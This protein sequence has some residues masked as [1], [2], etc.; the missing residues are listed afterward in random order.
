MINIKKLIL[1]IILVLLYS[2]SASASKLLITDLDVDVGD[3]TDKNLQEGDTISDEAAP[4]SEVSFEIEVMNNFTR[5]EDIEIEDITVTVY[6]RNIDDDD[7]L[8]EESDEF[9]LKADKDK[10]VTVDFSLPL[11]VEEDSYT[12]DIEIEGKDENGTSHTVSWALYLD[13]DKES[14]L[15][16]LIKADLEE[17]S[18][19]CPDST[20]LS[21]EIVNI[22][23]NEEED[24]ELSVSNSDLDI[25]EN[26]VFTLTED[27]YDSDSTY[28]EKLFIDIPNDV[29]GGSY[30]LRLKA[31]YGSRV[32]EQSL[33]LN[34]LCGN[35]EEEEEE[36][37]EAEAPEQEEEEET[38][39]M[40]SITT[41]AIQPISVRPDS[42]IERYKYVIAVVLAY[43]VVF[44]ALVVFAVK[45]FRK[46]SY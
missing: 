31:A 3:K 11:E 34:V 6:I 27:P 13:L 46:R 35:E 24:V 15:L 36:E 41:T 32:L 25:N 7:D 1:L 30:I 4:E 8:E 43:L 23:A 20:Y 45:I 39:G 17:S 37:E 12:V 5:T 44:S 2:F 18:L 26:R 22:G 29:D 40:E 9:N 42:F 10:K 21:I 28:E 19:V 33:D 14:H 16:K 38:G